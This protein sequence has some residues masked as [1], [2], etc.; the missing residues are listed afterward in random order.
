MMTTVDKW[1]QIIYVAI[2][3]RNAVRDEEGDGAPHVEKSPE[4]VL[5]GNSGQLDSLELISTLISVEQKVQDES[6]T[7]V[8]ITDDRV[9]SRSDH[10][11]ATV[12]SLASYIEE[13]VQEAKVG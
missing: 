8:S 3:E 4:T 9:I 10:P 7:T 6:G 13:L 11:F 1:I 12:T 2:D 5:F